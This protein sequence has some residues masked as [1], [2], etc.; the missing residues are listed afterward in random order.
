M[1]MTVTVTDISFYCGV[2]CLLE[3]HYIV[4]FVPTG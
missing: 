4:Q 3:V 2:C 1:H